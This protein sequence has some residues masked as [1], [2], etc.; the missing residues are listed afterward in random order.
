MKHRLINVIFLFSYSLMGAQTD[1]TFVPGNE[2]IDDATLSSGT[3]IANNTLT[4]HSSNINSGSTVTL[5]AGN[6]VCLTGT[7]TDA[8]I[9]DGNS[10]I[11]IIE[12][13]CET[14]DKPIISCRLENSCAS[15]YSFNNDFWEIT[16]TDDVYTF[17]CA[18]E[19]RANTGSNCPSWLNYVLIPPNT[20]I[21][22]TS[23]SLPYSLF[24]QH[25]AI[26]CGEYE[27]SFFSGSIYGAANTPLYIVD[28]GSISQSYQIDHHT[29]PYIYQVQEL[30]YSG[31][32]IYPDIPFEVDEISHLIVNP[33]SSS[34]IVKYTPCSDNNSVIVDPNSIFVIH[35]GIDCCL[36]VNICNLT[37]L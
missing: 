18:V 27:W 29:E 13:N 20:T 22:I 32:P 2:H 10:N 25:P 6:K 23:S 9:I 28:N 37:E 15:F 33:T 34:W 16:N 8:L 5:N 11:E 35:D 36:D 21:D 1:C 24:I 12:N 7:T 19:Y 31:N 30:V 4:I 26:E 17:F 3:Y 14:I